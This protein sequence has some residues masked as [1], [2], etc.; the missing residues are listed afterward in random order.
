MSAFP[1]RPAAIAGLAG[2]FICL[3]GVT[4]WGGDKPDPGDAAPVFEAVDQNGRTWRL[5]DHLGKGHLVVYFYPG[6]FTDG[7]AKQA[8]G[9]RDQMNLLAQK[10]ISVVGVSGDT[11]PT[12]HL[13]QQ[14]Y[15]LN[16]TLLSDEAGTLAAQFGVPFRPGGKARARNA[17]R[18]P[19]YV[20]GSRKSLIV[21]RG[22]TV[23]RW[24]FVID[25]AGNFLNVEANVDPRKESQRIIEIVDG[26]ATDGK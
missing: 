4:A 1:L 10:G 14:L 9:F 18:R 15:N 7:C 21:E 16:F 17:E 11:V 3:L 26:L 19:F 2:G 20:N 13:F 23:D 5:A 8:E 24:T 6:D 12:H 22:V 25:P